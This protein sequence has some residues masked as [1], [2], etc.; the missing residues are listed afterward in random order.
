M[1]PRASFLIDR[2]CRVQHQVANNLPLTRNVDEAIRIIEALQFTE[3]YG[4]VCPAGWHKDDRTMKTDAAG[5]AAYLR[6]HAVSL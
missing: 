3:E 1:A 2:G 4:E 6:D 5:V